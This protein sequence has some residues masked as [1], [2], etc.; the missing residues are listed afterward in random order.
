MASLYSIEKEA[1]W[2]TMKSES[3]ANL[4]IFLEVFLVKL[5]APESS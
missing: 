2:R 1:I 4:I 3:E 5:K